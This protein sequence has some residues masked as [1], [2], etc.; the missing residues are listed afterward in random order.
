MAIGALTEP[1][2]TG[3]K[4]AVYVYPSFTSTYVRIPHNGAYAGKGVPAGVCA[5]GLSA[6]LS[7]NVLAVSTNCDTAVTGAGYVYLWPD[8]TK[9]TVYQIVPPFSGVALTVSGPSYASY[10]ALSNTTLVVSYPYQS[11]SGAVYV[12]D[13]VSILFPTTP[14]PTSALP[15]PTTGSPSPTVS[16]IPSTPTTTAITNAPMITTPLSNPTT[17]TDGLQSSTSTT[18]RSGLSRSDKIALG[19]ALGIGLPSLLLAAIG[20]CYAR[21]P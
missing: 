2:G 18:G 19:T 1:I 12:F 5:F 9:S 21:K 3:P 16:T 20:I 11:P 6:A 13:L 10:V 4:G 14:P 7:G 8:Y 15:S 17:I